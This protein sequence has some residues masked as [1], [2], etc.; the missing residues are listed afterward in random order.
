MYMHGVVCF[1]MQKRTEK[2]ILHNMGFST[3]N[4]AIIYCENNEAN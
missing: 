1:P 2:L 3:K 4:L